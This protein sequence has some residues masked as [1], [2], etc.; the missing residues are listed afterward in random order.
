[1]W[2]IRPLHIVKS[3]P[4]LFGPTLRGEK[5]HEMRND[6][7]GYQ[8]GDRMLLREYVPAEKRYT[9]RMQLLKITYISRHGVDEE[10][11]AALKGPQQCILSVQRV[12]SILLNFT[13]ALVDRFGGP[14]PPETFPH[15]KASDLQP[16]A[17][18]P[19]PTACN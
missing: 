17:I 7:R 16:P 11:T 1:M 12:S 4:H 8:I 6:D 14:K 3:W 5:Q 18:E 19:P 15:L 2:K 9:G 10:A 13:N